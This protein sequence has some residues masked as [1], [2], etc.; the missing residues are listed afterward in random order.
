MRSC[1]T[2]WGGP[3]P[4]GGCGSGE[5]WTDRCIGSGKQ[6]GAELG[7]TYAPRPHVESQRS[8]GL[9]GEVQECSWG[10]LNL[11]MEVGMRPPTSVPHAPHLEVGTTVASVGQRTQW[12]SKYEDPAQ[13]GLAQTERLMNLPTVEVR[14][15]ESWRKG[16]G[17][18]SAVGTHS[19]VCQ[20]VQPLCLL[21]RCW[22]GQSHPGP[23]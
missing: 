22:P 1:R 6:E 9:K 8:A 15:A 3:A 12:V 19:C 20:C 18:P 7:G 13:Q 17:F 10:T 21:G 14:S 11:N 2:D 4:G 23:W 16:L 5:T